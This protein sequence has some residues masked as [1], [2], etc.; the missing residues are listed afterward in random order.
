MTHN[1]ERSLKAVVDFQLVKNV[2][3]MRLYGFFADK[4][5]LA[6]FLVGEPLSH[7][8]QNF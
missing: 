7:Q 3:Q 2:R 4:Y 8:S 5:F 6:D 1:Q